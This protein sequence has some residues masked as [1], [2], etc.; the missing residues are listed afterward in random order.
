MS[1]GATRCNGNVL[2][3]WPQLHMIIDCPLRDDCCLFTESSVECEEGQWVNPRWD[4]E[5][6][7][8]YAPGGGVAT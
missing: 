7:C 3:R 5:G 8:N 2:R 6:C 4:G 1:T